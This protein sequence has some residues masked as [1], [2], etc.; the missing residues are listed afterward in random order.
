MPVGGD[1]EGACGAPRTQTYPE[2]SL[3][4]HLF[5]I[6]K[7]SR[8]MGKRII[9]PQDPERLSRVMDERARMIGVREKHDFKYFLSLT[10]SNLK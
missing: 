3:F 9:P 7:P 1:L 5:N 10:S 8:A 2:F 4:I 6:L